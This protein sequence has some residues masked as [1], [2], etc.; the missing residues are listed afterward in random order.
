VSPKSVWFKRGRGERS[1]E[2]CHELPDG[3]VQLSPDSGEN[4]DVGHQRGRGKE[5]RG[6][7]ELRVEWEEN[8]LN[9]SCSHR[10]GT[11]LRI[12]GNRFETVGAVEK[13]NTLERPHDRSQSKAHVLMRP[14]LDTKH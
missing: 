3:G 14:S 11:K 9:A 6:R 12:G 10:S 2:L 1:T 5:R 7:K 13:A 4:R 8:R